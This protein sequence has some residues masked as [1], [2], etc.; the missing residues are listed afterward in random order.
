MNLVRDSCKR[1]PVQVIADSQGDGGPATV[2]LLDT[3][4]GLFADTSGLYICDAGNK[5]IRK[6]GNNGI[7]TTVVGNGSIGFSGGGGPATSAK[8]N[9]PEDLTIFNNNLFLVTAKM[10]EF[11]KWTLQQ[12][13]LPQ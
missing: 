9:F 4:T 6:V 8:I 5:R 10:Q 11:V 12:G 13:S 2:A 7:T 3:I 1:L